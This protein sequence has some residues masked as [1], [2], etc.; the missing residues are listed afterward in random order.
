M[1]EEKIVVYFDLDEVDNLCYE[2]KPSFGNRSTTVCSLSIF[3]N[4]L[5][6]YVMGSLTLMTL[7]RSFA[8]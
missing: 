8:V 4:V 5:S 2:I 3:S 6:L 1:A 7:K